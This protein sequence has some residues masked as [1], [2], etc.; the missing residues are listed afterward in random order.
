MSEELSSLSEKMRSFNFLNVLLALHD[1]GKS[2]CP[3][4]CVFV[5]TLGIMNFQM[6]SDS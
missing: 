3:G 2:V 5:C 6:I 1:V 4:V